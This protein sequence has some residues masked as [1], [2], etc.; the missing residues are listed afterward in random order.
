MIWRDGEQACVAAANECGI[1]MNCGASCRG[2]KK[3]VQEKSAEMVARLNVA[4]GHNRS[5][6]WQE[7]GQIRGRLG[8]K[9]FDRLCGVFGLWRVNAEETNVLA[10]TIDH[11]DERVTIDDVVNIGITW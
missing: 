9:T 7:S 6:G 4:H 11:D 2:R 10:T 5:A 1:D 8:A 3:E